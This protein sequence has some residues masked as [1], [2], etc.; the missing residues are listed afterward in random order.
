MLR[1]FFAPGV[2]LTSQRGCVRVVNE[3]YLDFRD[4][5]S[6]KRLPV[7]GTTLDLIAAGSAPKLHLYVDRRHEEL[8]PIFR[9]SIGPIDAVFVADPLDMR[10]VFNREGKYPQHVLPDA[11][12]LY[13]K[14]FGCS[15]GL[16]FM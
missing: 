12:V 16:F 14:L 7:F 9:E 3:P 4:I 5:P 15:R 1:K 8:G 11:W 2:K 6:P 10:A 13:N